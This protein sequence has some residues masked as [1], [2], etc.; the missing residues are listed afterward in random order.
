M[1][2]KHEMNQNSVQIKQVLHQNQNTGV[3][4]TALWQM[5]RVHSKVKNCQFLKQKKK[6]NVGINIGNPK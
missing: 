5:I 6:R 1:V 3:L 4:S 2:K